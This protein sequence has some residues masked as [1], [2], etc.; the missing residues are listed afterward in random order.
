MLVSHPTTYKFIYCLRLTVYG[1]SKLYSCAIGTFLLPVAK[2]RII[3]AMNLLSQKEYFEAH[4]ASFPPLSP[5]LSSFVHLYRLA[6][7][8]YLPRHYSTLARHA[9]T[10]RLRIRI[11][12]SWTCLPSHVNSYI[13]RRCPEWLD[14]HTS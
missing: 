14:K 6:F 7:C 2:L 10:C 12:L 13:D 4:P 5:C 8:D 3:F 11:L 9:E 1:S